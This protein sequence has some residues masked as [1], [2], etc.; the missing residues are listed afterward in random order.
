VNNKALCLSLTTASGTP[1][2]AFGAWEYYEEINDSM[3]SAGARY[4]GTLCGTYIKTSTAAATLFLNG[5][6]NTSGSQTISCIG[7]CSIT[8]IG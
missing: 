7:N 6:A 2:N 8:R 4:K 3:G 1:V 5:Y